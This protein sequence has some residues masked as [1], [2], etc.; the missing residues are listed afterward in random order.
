[1]KVN[2][3]KL[4]I[5]RSGLTGVDTQFKIAATSKA[6]EILSSGIYKDGITAILRELGANAAD[7]HK[8][9]GR[10]HAPFYVHLPST[11]EPW[12]SL[13]DEG[14]GLSEERIQT[15]YTTYFASDKT[16]SND[17]T[18][19]LGLGSKSPFAYA[20]QFTITSI[21]EK[22]K[23]VYTAFKDESSVPSITKLSEE[24]C[25]AH[26]G[27][28]IK[29]AV[30][31]S[32]F[33][34]FREKAVAVYRWFKPLPVVPAIQK[35]EFEND[36]VI[37]KG[38]N[39]E[40]T[41]IH[42]HEL[43]V[44][45]GP[46]AYPVDSSD[47]DVSGWNRSEAS[48]LG[49]GLRIYVN[50]GDVDIAASRE[51]LKISPRTNKL[52]RSRISDVLQGIAKETE[53]QIEACP[54]L[55]DARL[56]L[57]E[58]A[59]IP[60]MANYL[61]SNTIMWRGKPVTPS[62][63]TQTYANGQTTY[64]ISNKWFLC[65]GHRTRG[66]LSVQ[67]GASPTIDAKEDTK[68]YVNDLEKGHE[69]RIAHYCRFN[70]GTA[71]YLLG[72]AHHDLDG[73]KFEAFV[74]LHEIRHLLQKTSSLPE[75]PKKVY[76]KSKP[77]FLLRLRST[78][79]EDVSSKT[80]AWEGVKVQ[81]EDGGV[82]VGLNSYDWNSS[83]F[84]GGVHNHPKSLLQFLEAAK[85]FLGLE[86]TDVI[87]VRKHSLSK[88]EHAKNWVTLADFVLQ[89]IKASN[90]LPERAAKLVLFR[91]ITNTSDGITGSANRLLKLINL[92]VIHS[93]EDVNLGRKHPM[94][95]LS[96]FLAGLREASNEACR[97]NAYH[98][99][100][101]CLMEKVVDLPDLSLLQKEIQQLHQLV[102]NKY[103]LLLYPDCHLSGKELTGAVKYIQAVDRD[104][105]RLAREAQKEGQAVEAGRSV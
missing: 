25:Q 29:F 30:K 62:I 48:I 5:E 88:F 11:I 80:H 47:I 90:V 8:E 16:D 95:K 105:H 60:Y 74:D 17:L 67:E 28:E 78:Q 21:H 39:W 13:K 100:R 61:L 49:Q 35:Y 93:F 65:S 92:S 57:K 51:S 96:L 89:K 40:F 66:R 98:H 55:W 7:S 75:P 59:D 64:Y 10:M 9:A 38:S 72:P 85:P 52:I 54:T 91:T 33:S 27:V 3:A 68:L 79:A 32:D 58:I 73:K 87:A 46:I 56:R 70:Q 18:G 37:L 44:I 31:A 1:V 83:K 77:V 36:K 86:P 12:F 94:R 81:F 97:I 102:S 2:E 84:I 82:Y 26:N 103:P 22:V 19:C 42:S 50:M 4:K 23:R 34:T 99:C 43:H 63:K 6:F 69:A 24:P 14:I 20:D 71:I 104:N 76:A 45:M 53:T 15:I 41:G 101:T